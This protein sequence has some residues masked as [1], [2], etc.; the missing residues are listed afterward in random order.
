MRRRRREEGF[1]LIEL[2][3]VCVVLA[4]L[5]SIAIPNYSR[6]RAQSTRAS[7]ASNQRNIFAAA[8]LYVADNLTI[9]ATLTSKDLY[10]AQYIPE[11]MS[12]CPDSQS[13]DHND[14]E[15]TVENGKV[16]DI[17]CTFAAEHIWNP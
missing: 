8:T 10:D 5:A 7:C 15:I 17:V 6:T 4:V 2:S 12:N 14:Y 3:I 13:N 11:K 1:T 16:I 9:D